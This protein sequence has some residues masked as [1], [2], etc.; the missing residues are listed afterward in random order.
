MTRK[1]TAVK[2]APD[3][4]IAGPTVRGTFFIHDTDNRVWDGKTWRGFGAAEEYYTHQACFR[5]AMRIKR[6]ALT[7]DVAP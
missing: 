1:A 3:I 7:K 5:E 6:G 4:R 2:R